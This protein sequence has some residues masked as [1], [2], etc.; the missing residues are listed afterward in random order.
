MHAS[1]ATYYK[2]E[3]HTVAVPWLYIPS[4]W[5]SPVDTEIMLITWC[6][7]HCEKLIALGLVQMREHTF[8]SYYCTPHTHTHTHTQRSMHYVCGVC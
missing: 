6:A 7:Y 5:N 1:V 2:L 8:S 4:D 3:L